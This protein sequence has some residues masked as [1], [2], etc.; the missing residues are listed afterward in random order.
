[1]NYY[2]L[3]D[4]EIKQIKEIEEITGTNY[5]VENGMFNL[6]CLD[7]LT[8]DLLYEYNKLKKELEE[9]KKDRDNNYY[10]KPRPIEYGE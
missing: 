9:V 8:W 4:N 6:D 10:P 3:N 2:E 1:M 5:G 7:G